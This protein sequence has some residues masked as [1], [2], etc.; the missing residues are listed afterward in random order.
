MRDFTNHRHGNDAISVD[1]IVRELQLEDPSPVVAYKPRGIKSER[2]PLLQ[3]DNFLLILMTEFQVNL[4][5]RFSTLVC[6]D[7]T[8]N[9]N[10]YGYKL[11]SMVVANEYHNRKIIAVYNNR[12]LYSSTIMI[13]GQPIAWAIVDVEDTTTY[14]EF[15]KA[16]KTRVHHSIIQV[17][18]TDDGKWYM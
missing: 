13:T 15:F 6:V 11:C 17:L 1:R 18:M 4:F 5:Q 2:H 3:E 14:E 8:H 16:V 9:T 10:E 12:H 7:T